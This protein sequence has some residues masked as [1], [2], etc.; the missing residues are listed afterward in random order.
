[1]RTYIRYLI[2][3]R[4]FL[5]Y[6]SPTFSEPFWYI[7]STV[8]IWSVRFP[9]HHHQ[10]YYK[11]SIKSNHMTRPRSKLQN[12]QKWREYRGRENYISAARAK[13]KKKNFFIGIL[14]RGRQGAERKYP[15]MFLSLCH[16]SAEPIISFPLCRSSE[17]KIY[18]KSRVLVWTSDYPKVAP[19][20]SGE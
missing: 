8:P 12:V 11:A 15:I 3:L 14:F 13:K 19:S 16:K 17:W 10:N 9:C 20:A 2:F 1:M 7:V 5:S 4:I 6:F 18:G